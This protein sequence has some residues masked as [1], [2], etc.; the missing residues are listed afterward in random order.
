MFQ[1]RHYQE[2]ARI[3]KILNDYNKRVEGASRG[4]TLEDI[5]SV[6]AEELEYGVNGN[7]NFNIEKWLEAIYGE[8]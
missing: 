2:I 3:F 5:T 8:E 1:R 7:P 6:F 4:A